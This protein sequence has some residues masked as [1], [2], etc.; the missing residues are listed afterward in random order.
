MAGTFNSVINRSAAESLIPTEYSNQIIQGAVEESVVLR[1]AKRL[2]NMTSQMLSMPVL[3]SLPYAYF[4][5]GDTGMKQ[6]TDVDWTNK[7]ITAE[8]IAVIVPIPDNV[9]ADASFDLWAQINPLVRQAFGQRIDAAILYGTDKP[10]S[11]PTGIVPD[12]IAKG[13]VVTQ[14]TDGYADIMAPDGLIALVEEDGYFVNGY[15]G[16]MQSRSYLRNIRD[17]NGQPL[18]RNGMTDATRYTLDGQPIDFP[19]NGSIDS[20][21]TTL[22]GGDWSQLVYAIR[23]DMTVT[24]TNTGVISDDTGKIIY[25]LYQQDMTALR[26]VMRLGWQLPNPLNNIG[27][28]DRYPFAVLKPAASTGA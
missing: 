4:V 12:A 21:S 13:N 5:N 16:S 6:T 1:K 9:I 25:N 8:E 3:N 10:T 26:F 18:F 19:R 23:Q 11:W 24:R 17:E 22:I 7:I 14:T 27:G 2:P 20:E 28:T 15:V